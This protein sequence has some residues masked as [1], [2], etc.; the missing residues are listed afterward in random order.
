MNEMK[1][2]NSK[3]QHPEKIQTPNPKKPGLDADGPCF[4]GAWRLTFLWSLELG[5]WSL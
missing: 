1:A 3:L 2:P 4:I 5:I